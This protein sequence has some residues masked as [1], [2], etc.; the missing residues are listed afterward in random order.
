MKAIL[1]NA[2]L[3]VTVVNNGEK[4][5]QQLAKERY[6]IILMDIS[7]PEM[8][9]IEATRHI[10]QLPGRARNIP[11]VALTAHA[12]SGDR[13]RFLEAGMNDYLTKPVK[14]KKT[15]ECIARW[16]GKKRDW[17]EEVEDI[18]V[19]LEEQSGTQA[20]FIDKD[21]I[22][23]LIRDTSAET[24][25]NLIRL[26]IDDGRKRISHLLEAIS[27]RNV[28]KLQFEAHTLGSS[29][30][31]HGNLA[32][33]DLMRKIEHHCRSDNPDEA[34]VE[35]E[36]LRSVADQSFEELEKMAA[37]GFESRDLPSTTGT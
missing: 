5:I 23:Q 10:R 6:D 21:V 34:F 13:E 2:D 28:E 33:H 31:T 4:A 36:N 27:D 18:G 14:V 32:L 9:G 11:I 22:N 3:D 29:A 1:G 17:P 35:A 7:M 20:Q 19:A 24:V 12:L 26:Y 15:L 8:D 25:T 37:A 16:T 30:A